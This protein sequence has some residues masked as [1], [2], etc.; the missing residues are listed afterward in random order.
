[1]RFDVE[2]PRAERVIDVHCHILPGLDD[3]A[4]DLDDAVAMAAQAAEDGVR[5]ICATPHIRHDH[6]VVVAEIAE[7]VA[8]LNRELA[9]AA[10]RVRVE[11]GGEVAETALDR[12]DRREL[13]QVALGGGR[14]VLVEPA[15]GPLADGLEAAVAQLD[16]R[17][18]GTIVAHPERHA[19]EQLLF[20][21]E[22]LVE[23]GALVQVTAALL[24]EP[25]SGPVMLDLARRGLVHL[26]GSDAH[27]SRAG[28]PAR[29]SA[30]VAALQAGGLHPGEI[31]LIVRGL[32]HAVLSGQRF[33]PP[34]AGRRD[35]SLV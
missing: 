5:R 24:A 30:G 8:A 14:W 3:G 15:P 13:A 34:L 12:L 21:L 19:D 27:S 2:P 22:R 10:L 17:G 4:V 25:G 6:D 23:R 16:R 33:A 31:D 1:M 18:F 35:H 26:L 28:R 29:L 32:P 9:R 7:R 20:R 11:T